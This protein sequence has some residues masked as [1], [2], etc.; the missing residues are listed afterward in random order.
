VTLWQSKT[1]G[2]PAHFGDG[3]T[4]LT[5]SLTP[6]GTTVFVNDYA[7][8]G[9]ISAQSAAANDP[10]SPGSTRYYQ[11]IYYDRHRTFCTSAVINSSNAI[12]V[13]WMP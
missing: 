2:L 9:S 4:C 1:N 13:T 7:A 6:I 3:A 5:G 8:W 10:I 12:A 11:A